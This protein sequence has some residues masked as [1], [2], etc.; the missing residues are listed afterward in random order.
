LVGLVWPAEGVARWSDELEVV[1]AGRDP[2]EGI[3]AVGGR[4]RRT[5]ERSS[6]GVEVHG[7]ICEAHLARVLDPIEIG[8][9][10]DEATYNCVPRAA[11]TDC[12]IRGEL[13]RVAVRCCVGEGRC[14]VAPVEGVEG[15]V[16]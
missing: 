10:P 2:G 1:I 11:T 9:V 15:D 8:V 16:E 12:Q 4:G 6:N 5:H 3:A 7:D 13:P 14:D